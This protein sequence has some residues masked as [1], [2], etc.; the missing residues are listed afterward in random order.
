MGLGYN[1]VLTGISCG[2]VF[3]NSILIGTTICKRQII[4]QVQFKYREKTIYGEILV[5]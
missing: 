4:F 3:K 1:T 5:D 2:Q